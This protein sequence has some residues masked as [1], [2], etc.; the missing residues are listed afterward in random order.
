LRGRPCNM[1]CAIGDTSMEKSGS[2][3]YGLGPR[4]A[5]IARSAVVAVVLLLALSAH[6]GS[7]LASR[8]HA[9]QFPRTLAQSRLS[10]ARGGTVRTRIGV[11]LRVPPNVMRRSGRASIAEVA[12]GEY[13]IHIAAPWS[14]TVTVALPMIDGLPIIAHR[15]LGDWRIESARA[16]GRRAIAQ[17]RQL[18]LFGD[19]A[20]CIKPES[21]HGLLI[22]L[23][24]AG[25]RQIAHG[26]FEKIVDKIIPPYDPCRPINFSIDLT[27]L[28]A[29]CPAVDGPPLPPPHSTPPQGPP[30]SPP[31]ESAPSPQPTPATPTPRPPPATTT[32][33][34]HIYGTCADGAC[35]LKI[36]SGP[37]YSSYPQIGSLV[38]GDTVQIVC[39]AV[40]ETV[41]PSP[42]TG[43]SSAIWDKLVNGGWVS[44]LYVDTP[45]VGVFSPP[46][47]QC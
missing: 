31:S 26:I 23:L 21:F 29:A 1:L 47:P 7:A 43:N 13:A 3:V 20:K 15:I 36:R 24:K 10:A 11:E 8:G 41:G 42:A 46:I 17:V 19:L 12:Q 25:V 30:T 40:G 45:N 16:V 27:D 2:S 9:N 38:D 18:S 5:R 32:Y 35:G 6:S 28:L 22:C 34:Y 39:Q 33:T 14:G 4:L 44:D 37:G